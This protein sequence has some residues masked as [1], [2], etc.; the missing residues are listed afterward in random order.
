MAVLLIRA[1]NSN[2]RPFL[3]SLL[4]VP[5]I[6]GLTDLGQAIKS[7]SEEWFILWLPALIVAAKS[8]PA[9]RSA[10]L[11]NSHYVGEDGE[12]SAFHKLPRLVRESRLFRSEKHTSE[13]QALMRLSYAVS[14]LKKK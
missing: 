2:H 8:H 1:W 11:L 13:L 6:A 12:G 14:C 9:I 5:A 3:I 7:P 10:P 4:S